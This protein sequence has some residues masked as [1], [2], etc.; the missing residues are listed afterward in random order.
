M[1]DYLQQFNNLPK[2]LRDQVSSPRAMALI[3]ELEE[4]YK[5]DL[6]I[7]VMKI[8]VKSLSFSNLPTYLSG[9]LLLT[10]DAANQ[11][12]RDLKEKLF[13]PLADYLGL[14]SAIRALDLDKDIGVIIK[15]AGLVLPS[16]VAVG[17][18]KNIVATY[19]RGVR[20]KIDTRSTLAKDVKIGGLNLSSEEID[21]VLKICDTRVSKDSVVAP[22][23]APA[24]R[25]APRAPLVAPATSEYNL[26]QALAKGETKPIIRTP[27]DTSHELAGLKAQ[28]DLSKPAAP[29][30]PTVG[31]K[32]INPVSRP[33]SHLESLRPSA[34]KIVPTAPAAPAAPVSLAAARTLAGRQAPAPSNIR[35]QMHDIKPLPKVMGPIEELQFLDVVNFR[36]LAAT[37]VEITSKILAKIKLLEK[38]GYDKMVAGVRA[39]R[40]SPASRLYLR[41]GQEAITQGRPLKEIIDARKTV[42]QDYL[43]LDEIKAIVSLN[44]QLM[45]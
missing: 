44:S 10:P 27:L 18:F 23:A 39:W 24:A 45:F 35:P 38:D 33:A 29:L 12:I 31:V 43:S 19:V 21:R 6:A 8:M 16:A 25:I 4:K 36:R 13:A 26:K 5:V 37:P 40:Q 3:L 11:L 22:A 34:P 32:T 28:L 41:L 42:G 9:E 15:E 14:T 2:N 20:N 17:R 1:F 30:K 7:V